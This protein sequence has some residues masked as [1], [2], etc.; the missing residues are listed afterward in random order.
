MSRCLSLL[1]VGCLGCGAASESNDS[2]TSALPS[3]QMLEV[4]LAAADG[5][6][7]APGPS[8]DVLGKTAGLAVLTRQTTVWVNTVVGDTLDRV[9]SIARSQPAEAGPDNA[10][11]GP[12]AD[13]TSPLAW[14]LV[15]NRVGPGE[16]TFQLQV[17][18]SSGG[19]ADF[20]AFLQ[21]VSE[22]VCPS[23]PNQG[24]FSIN[25]SIAHQLDP[26]G[27]PVE[28]QVVAGWTVAAQ[29]RDVHVQL[30]GVHDASDP[31]AT[32][33]FDATVLADGSGALTFEAHANLVG[34]AQTLE[35]GR[36]GARWSTS[37][38]GQADAE[39]HGGDV[40]AGGVLLEC[41]NVGSDLVY[42]RAVGADGGG[43]TH[44]DASACVFGAP[45]G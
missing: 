44:G 22:G 36:V 13:A 4:T 32:G 42:L 1:L 6:T 21:G 23:G 38:A 43:D 18:P 35:V 10:V 17:R 39:V 45:V 29:G 14:R 27:H 25:F 19:D 41:W 20:Q 7:A 28:G 9:S 8:L 34:S 26:V 15:V 3:R 5:G 24:T 40:G 11:W 33:V 16:H 31:P 37:G 12:F 30:G 2:L